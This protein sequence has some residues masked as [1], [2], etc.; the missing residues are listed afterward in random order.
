M[1]KRNYNHF[2]LIYK[3]IKSNIIL[4][5]D[6]L[7]DCYIYDDEDNENIK[8]YYVKFDKDLSYNEIKELQIKILND[9]YYYCLNSGFPEEFQNISLFLNKVMP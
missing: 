9:I 7:V 8:E 4:K 1:E 2:A 3:Y 6:N 5:Y